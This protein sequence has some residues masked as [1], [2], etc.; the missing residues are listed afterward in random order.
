MFEIV[1]NSHFYTYSMHMSIVVAT[2]KLHGC[3]V[4]ILKI[5]K[6]ERVIP[7]DL[8][9]EIVCNSHF[10]NYTMYRSVVMA[11]IKLGVACLP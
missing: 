1:C 8:R 4:F 5:R 7:G 6:K 9:F 2:V 11:T 3:G 10:Y